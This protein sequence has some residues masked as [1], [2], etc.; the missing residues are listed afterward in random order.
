MK[1]GSLMRAA[2]TEERARGA[3]AV[4]GAELGGA[5]SGLA[6]AGRLSG[7]TGCAGSS[8]ISR[9]VN[10]GARTRRGIPKSNGNALTRLQD[11]TKLSFATT[12]LAFE[13]RN[14]ETVRSTTLAW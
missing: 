4:L 14:A 2:D 5:A 9:L 13:R 11:F 6:A 3:A 12:N 8:C 1:G 7:A 10:T